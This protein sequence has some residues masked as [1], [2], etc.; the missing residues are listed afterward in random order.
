MAVYIW[1]AIALT[2]LT[3]LLVLLTSMLC[4]MFTGRQPGEARAT[5]ASLAELL[6]ELGLDP[7]T[8]MPV[9]G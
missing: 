9:Q 5:R 2:V 8:G 1:A 3:S 4:S 6:Q 7:R